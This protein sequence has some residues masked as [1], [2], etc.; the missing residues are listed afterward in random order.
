MR[1]FT[2]STISHIHLS[3]VMI[4]SFCRS[5][6]GFDI[7]IVVPD[8]NSDNRI[9]IQTLIG[10]NIELLSP[11]DLGLLNMNHL[12]HYYGALEF[13]SAMKVVGIHFFLL[14]GE[15]VLF[16]D[17]DTLIL[18]SLQRSLIDI[19]GDVLLSPH[20][21][22][23][24]PNDPFSPNDLDI[25][26]SGHIN[27]GLILVR[28]SIYGKQVIDWLVSK[29]ESQWFVAPKVGLYADQLWLSMLPYLFENAVALIMDRGINVAYWNVHERQIG[30]TAK[31]QLI[32]KSGETV[33][34]LHFSGFD[35]SGK[36]LSK[37]STRSLNKTTQDAL[38]SVIEEY[39]NDVVDA[40][41]K[42]SK[43]DSRMKF[44]RGPVFFRM[45]LAKIISKNN[46]SSASL[47][48]HSEW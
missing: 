2:V 9:K 38:E 11:N 6:S 1:V 39:R 26:R 21:F 33:K 42:Y 13:C 30:A 34:L 37:H 27:G 18:D 24:Y 7:S 4:R 31:G 15:D 23:P 46:K 44:A 19:P 16:L 40:Q 35:I 22:K 41:K 28:N 20:T 3:E 32:L 8:L 36:S 45:K 43:I 12:R 47:S 48:G 5:H 14:R 10:E 25:I 17:P 29:V